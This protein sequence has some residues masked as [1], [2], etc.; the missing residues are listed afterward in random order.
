MKK[1]KLDAD[2]GLLNADCMDNVLTFAGTTQLSILMMTSKYYNRCA[3]VTLCKRYERKVPKITKRVYHLGL[4]LSRKSREI[5]P[6]CHVKS[7]AHSVAVLGKRCMMC[8]KPCRDVCAYGFMAHLRCIKKKEIHIRS[9]YLPIGFKALPPPL[10]P[11]RRVTGSFWSR[12]D[13]KDIDYSYW[14][15]INDCI[16][17][18]YPGELS[19]NTY[20]RKVEEVVRKAEEVVRDERRAEYKKERAKYKKERAEMGAKKK[21]VDKMREMI[22]ELKG[23]IDAKYKK[24]V[25]EM[26][27]K[28]EKILA[29]IDAMYKKNVAAYIKMDM[30]LAELEEAMC[31]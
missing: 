26:A 31:T 30:M 11:V 24:S 4:L 15:A 2:Q 17:G 21:E 7:L 3:M 23:G 5:L 16:P 6:R 1:Q 9:H 10:L 8:K 27:A 29:E 13:D 22:A 19:W 25:D 12:P 20:R 14:C 28:M 18:I